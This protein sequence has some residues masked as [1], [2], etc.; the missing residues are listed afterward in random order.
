MSSFP[1]QDPLAVPTFVFF[2][3]RHSYLGPFL[4]NN[5]LIEIGVFYFKGKRRLEKSWRM[6]SAATAQWRI[7]DFSR[8]FSDRVSSDLIDDI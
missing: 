1:S 2:V 7:S 6:Y 5:R 3:H 8:K 4:R